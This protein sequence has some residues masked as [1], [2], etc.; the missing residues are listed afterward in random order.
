[1][2]VLARG[3]RCRGR[4]LRASLGA[5]PSVV[6]STGCG[7]TQGVSARCRWVLSTPARRRGSKE[8]AMDR[9]RNLLEAVLIAL[10]AWAL[11]GHYRTGQDLRRVC[12]L[13]GPHDIA[14][15]HPT[16]APEEVDT[17]CIDHQPEE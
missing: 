14:Y 17:I 2:T 10:L 6:R 8:R 11:Y 13:I 9:G 1:M 16:T 4:C 5:V 3:V 15:F 12:E 7:A